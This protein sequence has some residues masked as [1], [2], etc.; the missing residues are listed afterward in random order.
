MIVWWKT[1]LNRMA[2]ELKDHELE[3]IMTFQEFYP[4]MC[5]NKIHENSD[6]QIIFEAQREHFEPNNLPKYIAIFKHTKTG[7]L[8]VA[9]IGVAKT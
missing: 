1:T 6:Y 8:R 2:F 3:E 5:K 9:H 7:Q 4:Y